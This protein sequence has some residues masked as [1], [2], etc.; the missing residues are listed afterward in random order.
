MPDV[1]SIQR[2]NGYIEKNGRRRRENDKDILRLSKEWY[3][4]GDCIIMKKKISVKLLYILPLLLVGAL[5]FCIHTGKIESVKGAMENRRDDKQKGKTEEYEPNPPG[6]ISL[7]DMFEWHT[8]PG[9]EVYDPY[10]KI[11]KNGIYGITVDERE[12]FRRC[13]E[14]QQRYSVNHPLDGEQKGSES[15]NPERVVRI[16][17]KFEL[18]REHLTGEVKNITIS[19]QITEEEKQY[20]VGNNGEMLKEYM[21]TEGNLLKIP[22]TRRY[23][24]DNNEI[25]TEIT[26]EKAYF[27]TA[28]ITLE[29]SCDW[30]QEST[31]VPKIKYLKDYGEVLGVDYEAPVPFTGEFI[32]KFNDRALYYDLGFYDLST[33][34][35]GNIY[36][37][38]MRKKEEVTFK[39]GYI[40]P[41]DFLELAYLSYDGSPDLGEQKYNDIYGVL[42]KL[43]E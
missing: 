38:P 12:W 31:V 17:K 14:K 27:V 33:P 34:E 26:E 24:S 1:T 39:A 40:I 5:V 32:S 25:I 30:V 22:V 2:K 21:D 19:T 10:N 37:Y 36:A 20:F 3:G 23:L 9:T 7:A 11:A 6:T 41:E 13:A 29:S 16:G 35:V 42:I 15:Y 4:T 18:V 43:T 8:E 28:E